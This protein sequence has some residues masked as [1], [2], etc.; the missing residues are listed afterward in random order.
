MSRVC[1]VTR[2]KG[3]PILL[4]RALRSVAQQTYRDVEHVIVND[5]G[6][7]AQFEEVIA[8]EA[9]EVTIRVIHNE[10]SR[11]MECASNQGIVAT[12]S[13][14]CIIHDD[15]DTWQPTYLERAIET[16]A[17]SRCAGLVTQTTLVVEELHGDDIV[18]V[19]RRAFNPDLYAVDLVGLAV[20]NLYPP[21]S[22]LFTR[23]AWLEVGKF[24]E[25]M[26]VLGDWDFNL[27]FVR[28][29]DV[30]VIAAPLACYHQRPRETAVY[31]NSLHAASHQHHLMRSYLVNKL[32]RESTP[33][34]TALGALMHFGPSIEEA[35]SV[36]GDLRRAKEVARGAARRLGMPLR[37]WSRDSLHKA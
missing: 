6:N 31:G 11:G 3:R 4:A 10:V 32:M 1:V 19:E 21:I 26:P 17:R 27:R 28:Q 30:E 34:A 18:E 15:D 16:L 5:G 8:S 24:D 20:Q 12:D 33:A 2:T 22:F 35:I 36:L 13:D 29:F 9:G 7:R 25:A 37:L 23:A 14:Y